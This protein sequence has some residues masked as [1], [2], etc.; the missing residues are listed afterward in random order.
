GIG[1][2]MSELAGWRC[3]HWQAEEALPLSPLS[4]FGVSRYRDNPVLAS[5]IKDERLWAFL[6]KAYLAP[7]TAAR[8][9]G[10]QLR[11]TL[12]AYFTHGRNRASA[13]AVLGVSRQTVFSNMGKVEALLGGPVDSYADSLHMALQLFLFHERP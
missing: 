6:R 12:L 10:Q 7:L 13:A 8:D 2:P 5:L 4:E 9:G 3:T 1:E 11:A